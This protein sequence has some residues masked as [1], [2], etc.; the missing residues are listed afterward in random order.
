MPPPSWLVNTKAG[1]SEL[2][3]NDPTKATPPALAPYQS[4]L[5]NS[6]AMTGLTEITEMAVATQVVS[7]NRLLLYIVVNFFIVH[8]PPEVCRECLLPES[9]RVDVFANN[10]NLSRSRSDFLLLEYERLLPILQTPDWQPVLLKGAALALGTY[11]E[12]TDRWFLDLDVLVP[13]LPGVRRH[14]ERPYTLQVD[15]AVAR[16]FVVEIFHLFGFH[17]RQSEGVHLVFTRRRDG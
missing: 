5:L 6:P 14:P 17:Q 3:L 16:W 7:N 9:A 2:Q 11:A 15:R 4:P 12:P 8:A 1:A 10:V 13:L